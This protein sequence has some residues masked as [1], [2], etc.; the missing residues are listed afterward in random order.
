M[1]TILPLRKSSTLFLTESSKGTMA[2][3][4]SQIFSTPT[5]PERLPVRRR[6]AGCSCCEV[7]VAAVAAVET[8][9]EGFLTGQVE[10]EL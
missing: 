2:P 5:S 9:E 4:S 3:L 1:L 10:E 6:L 8:V 7:M